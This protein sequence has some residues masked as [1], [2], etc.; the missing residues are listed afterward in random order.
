VDRLESSPGADSQLVVTVD[1]AHNA[2]S[3][4]KPD[5]TYDGGTG[6]LSNH[7]INVCD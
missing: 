4:L 6:L 2:L 1:D 3:K 7:V 5:D